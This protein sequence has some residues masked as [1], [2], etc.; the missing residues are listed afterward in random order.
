[1]KQIL[2]YGDSLSWGII[3]NTRQRHPFDV[4][5]PGVLEQQLNALGESVRVIENCVNG[6]RTVWEDPFKPGRDGRQGLATLIEACSPLSLVIL[7]LGSNDFQS[8]HPHTA[9]HSAQ[10]TAVL[11]DI[12]R[13]APIEPGMPVPPILIVAP[14]RLQEPRGIIAGKFVGADQ[15]CIGLPEE[16]RQVAEQLNCAYFDA[17]QII[18]TS[19]DDG[20]HLDADAHIALGRVLTEPV[21]GLI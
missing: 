15:K 1:M 18:T 2:V 11:V 6:R 19:V 16:L 10:G 13:N 20:V 8:M 5:W 4:R 17:S 14:P 21:R 9:W 3:P 7:M 12:I